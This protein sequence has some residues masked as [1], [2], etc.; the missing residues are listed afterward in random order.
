MSAMISARFVWNLWVE[1]A[2]ALAEVLKHYPTYA[3]GSRTV[4]DDLRGRLDG[5][6]RNADRLAKDNLRSATTNP[7]TKMHELVQ[8][9]VKLKE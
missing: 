9:L 8:F 5:A 4:F 7:S 6:I 3:K 1:R 2:A